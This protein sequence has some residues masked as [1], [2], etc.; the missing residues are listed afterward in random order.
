MKPIEFF[1]S[2]Q[3]KYAG[4][5]VLIGIILAVLCF[6][7]AVRLLSNIKTDL[8]NLLPDHYPTVRY[9]EE[10][11][12]KFNRRSSLYLI[13]NS[14][15]AE[16]NKKAMVASK[17]YLET[18]PSIDYIEVKKRG[19]DFFDKNK[20]LLLGLKDL[21][22][23]KNRLKDK[24]EQEKLGG[25]Y[26]SFEDSGDEKEVTF[27]D[28]IKKYKDEF[29]EGVRSPYKTNEDNTVYVLNIYP[30][31]NDSSLK[32][33]KSFGT[34]VQQYAAKFDFKKFSPDIEIGYAGAIVT[35]V[36]QYDALINDL[37]RAGM[38]SAI[39]IFL[40]LYFYFGRYVARKKGIKGFVITSAMRFVPVIS[41]FIP[42]IISIMVAFWFC[43]Y[44]FTHLNV[45]TSFLFAIILGLGVDIGIHLYTRYIQDRK[46]GLDIDQIHRSVVL[47]TG[48]SCAIGILT[49]V[50]SFYILTI[51]DF[52]GF[53][54]FGWIAGNGLVI[55]LLSYL[56]FFPSLMLL[57]DRFS[58][59]KVAKNGDHVKSA[60][61]AWI[62]G[63]KS[64]LTF[65]FI[66]AAFSI[67]GL[68]HL[69]FEWDFHK[70]KMKIPAREHQKVLL[71]QTHGRV[72]SPAVYLIENSIQANK[73][74]QIIRH[75]KTYDEGFH[76]IQYFRSYY[77]MFPMDQ[78]EKMFVLGD[79][80]KLLSDPLVI[81]SLNPEEKELVVDFKK[82]IKDTKPIIEKD[83]P[84]D[85]HEIFWGNTGNTDS[86]VAYI[87]PLPNLELDNGNNAKA[88][89]QDVYNVTALDYQYYALSDA[90][91][92]AEVLQ[93]LFRD[94]KKAILFASIIIFALI[95]LH[96]RH[97]RRTSLIFIGLGC[98]LLWMFGCM[99][100][101]DIRLNFY[102]MIVIPAM[103]GMGV[104]NSVHIV[105]RFDEI[106]RKAI[107][108]VLKT[109]GGA[110]LMASITTILGYSGLCFTHHPGL[111]SI[112][113]MAIIGM[114][115]CLIGS[116]VVLPLM[117]QLVLRKK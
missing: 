60:G 29:T 91:V 63:A 36:D 32:Y 84:P 23:I 113:W 5:I 13:I 44:F 78:D 102:N 88:F 42:M 64:I 68:Q 49:T 100:V 52:K 96:F 72:N 43:S 30:K 46:L 83:V 55:A 80:H 108:P 65:A 115:T 79:I 58:F 110:A 50:A 104:D 109:S 112:G 86:S 90:M 69:H 93:T 92:F 94:A 28:L 105:H 26:I 114:V 87:M 17:A 98:G 54:E 45:V 71:K 61:R 53:S 41:I 82:A 35:R 7:R 103:I 89:Y 95:S 21:Y 38:I 111:N 85:V 40:L 70:L 20:L 33:F 48:K 51:N 66:V 10:I 106:G 57:I 14:P 9:T 73:I 56:L 18:L 12:K 117:L 67:F 37:K 74:K 77:D 34:E 11:Q 16:I 3:K 22:D 81:R 25:L 59:F 97:V 24:I 1:L 116:L 107:I 31:S 39:S 15:H 75:R 99:V 76:T 6:P 62:P 2:I 8:I 27:D 4:T 19:Y 101:F 47:R